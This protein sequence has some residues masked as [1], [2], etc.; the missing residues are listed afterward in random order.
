MLTNCSLEE[1]KE[2]NIKQAISQ[3]KGNGIHFVNKDDNTLIGKPSEKFDIYQLGL[4]A[5][6]NAKRAQNWI[7]EKFKKPK[8]T[9]WITVTKFN[10][11]IEVKFKIPKLLEKAWE[12]KLK[13][14]SLEEYKKTEEQNNIDENG[15]TSLFQ[16]DDI[17]LQK[18]SPKTIALIKDLLKRIGVDIN[19]VEN[20][21]VNGKRIDANAVAILAKN[22]I[23]VIEGKEDVALTEEAMHFVVEIVKQ[24]NPVLYK[25]LLSEINKPEHKEIVSYVNENYRDLYQKDG[26]PDVIRLKEEAIGQVL[27]NRV[28]DRNEK[29]FTWWE[30]IVQW[31]KDLFNK[32]GID[33]LAKQV[34]NESFNEKAT[35]TGESLFQ[36]NNE[37]QNRVFDNLVSKANDVKKKDE[38]YFV[39]GKELKRVTSLVK[40]WYDRRLGDGDLTKSEFQQSVDDLKAEQGTKG[41]SYF[42]KAYEVFIDKNT[43]LPREQKLDD[44]EFLNSL[45]TR[46][47][48]IYE[49]LRDNFEQR[50]KSFPDS[51]FLS[52]VTVYNPKQNIGG[53]IDLIAIEPSGKVNIL[54]WKFMDLNTEKFQD[55]PWYKVA[56]WNIQ[57]VKYKQI[58]SQAYGVKNEEFG[59]TAM[60]PIQA[61]YTQGN[62]KE[63][64]LPVLKEVRIGDVD[65]KNIDKDF[66]LPVPT[67]DQK[68]GNKK[69]DALIV[70]LNKNYEKLSKEKVLP[71]EKQN[72]AEQLNALFSAI[73]LLQVKQDVKPLI[74]QAKILNK[75]IET[76]FNRYEMEFKGKT[77]QEVADK[78]NEFAGVLRV[79]LEALEP[80]LSLD[81]DLKSLFIG[82]LSLE[83]KELQK[84]LKETVDLV[85]DYKEHLQDLDK[86]FG[87]EFIGA[88]FSAER[89][90]KGIGKWLST[91]SKLQ[92]ANIQSLYK[93][94][95]KAFAL[96][97]MEN[98]V[99]VDRLQALKKSYQS[100]V[101]SKGLNIKNQFDILM[102]KDKNELIDQYNPEFY[103]EL[104]KRIQDKD[105]NW[106]KNN[107]DV[108]AYKEFLKEK[109]EQEYERIKNKP[110]T[111]TEE[112]ILREIKKET[113]KV[114]ELY[115]ISTPTSPGWLLK[116]Q[117]R[118][119]PLNEKWESQE[120]KELNKPE[121]KAAKDFY[122][123]IIE[124]NE[125]YREIGYLNN[126][127]VKKFLPWMRKG[128]MEKLVFGGNISLGEQFLR[129]ISLDENEAGLG[130]LDPLTGKPI[131]TVPKYFVTEIDGDY[132]TDLFKTIA[133]YNDHAIKF[134]N[135]TDIEESSLALLRA[136]QNKQ[137]IATSVFGRTIKEDG[138]IKFNDNNIENSQLLE[139]MIKAIVYQQRYVSDEAFDHMLGRL[140]NFGEKLNKKLGMNVFPENLSDRQLSINKSITQLN[141]IFQLNTLG[142]NSLSALSNSFGGRAQ[143]L[144][145][146]GKYF[147]KTDFI[148]TQAWILQNKLTGGEDRKLALAA[149][150]YFVP[151]TENYNKHA[152]NHLSLNKLDDQAVQDYLMFLMRNGDKAVQVLNFFS[153]LKN[154]IVLDDKV[155]NVREYLKTTDEYKE[156][157][158]GTQEERKVRKEKFEQDVKKLVE[159]KGV[160]KLG[161]VE[162]GK[163]VIP[164]VERTSDSVIELRRK[165][166]S[167][168]ADALGSLSEENKRLLNLNVYG[169]SM[170]IFKNWIPRL[171]EV[172]AGD[173]SYN[174]ASDAYEWGRMRMVFS[175][176]SDD[177]LHSLGNLKN[178]LLGNDKGMDYIRHL[179]EKKLE[180]YK[181][182][183]GKDLQMTE[184]EFID[185]MRQGIKNQA[186]D[187]LFFLSMIGLFAG[188]KAIPPDDDEDPAIINQYRFL[189]KATDKL[190]DEITYFYNPTSFSRLISQGAFPSIA[191][192]EN[193]E[194]IVTNFMKENYD[195]IT[196]DEE[197]QKKT[198]VLKYVMKSFPITSQVAA[199]LPMFYPEL[200]KDLGV[201]MQSQYG[202]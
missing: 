148:Q 150:D 193:Y 17:N 117:I 145:N 47:Q 142:F 173:I 51:K 181:L 10:K 82:D 89:A 192:I 171:V 64:I 92:S 83:D 44:S 37:K 35:S 67:P 162:D 153:F 74:N 9:N 52:E 111:G 129:S 21:I 18:A 116:K 60:I 43:G 156:F 164:N 110:R 3:F 100:W 45:T 168:T 174:A 191:L 141:N 63:N 194:K 84:D 87:E 133:L 108:E 56:A 170:M 36:L 39:N 68:I 113:F 70:K 61:V 186:V 16:L 109:R 183:T 30:S 26:K 159:E 57:M 202:F 114:N 126:K 128:L 22:L 46:E 184:D 13:N 99:E 24:T 198:Y 71:S 118:K 40:D 104:N 197:K 195:Y 8:F 167:F 187:T 19:K 163:F 85:S 27:A 154:S 4:I 123:Y 91:T 190:K 38:K 105:F 182:N 176:I 33:Q 54:D 140:G 146:A 98:Q 53:T 59:Q 1:I 179:Y 88:N 78:V 136:E 5:D 185:L 169:S 55:V 102:K 124:R 122:D 73:R 188:L 130:Q 119:F 90:I 201:R 29:E 31:I 11:E 15:Q 121:N 101:N 175:C 144:I 135:L 120:W 172:R 177:A 69:I 155:V 180:Q 34:V 2:S 65:V 94:A 72:K 32:S 189:L 158:K 58:L 7:N 66:L 75:Q 166:Q 139:K 199:Y 196:G 62:A 77:K 107:I 127:S 134:K 143:G 48:G 76:L 125:Y 200:A 50:I 25:K 151:F 131:N 97:N 6:A 86:S 95:N 165:V 161:K 160:L 49:V 28:I 152:I 20:I 80:Y 178:I 115:N 23:D 96:S 12:I 42:E 138:E 81:K 132:S 147:T 93:L 112:E 14:I 149:L 103:K 137:S 79:N 106:I 41:H 157:N